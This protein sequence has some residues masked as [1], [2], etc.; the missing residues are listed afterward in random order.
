MLKRRTFVSLAA[1]VA[2]V[3][4]GGSAFAQTLTKISVATAPTDGAK[5]L[6]WG[7]HAGTF[8]K[9]GLDV[10]IVPIGS[11]AAA[12]AALAGGS[13]Q[14][15]FGNILSIASGYTRGVP[16]VI[17]A[18]GDIY[19]TDHPY[20]LL[21]VKKD[22]DVRTG[23]DLANKAIASPALRD[24]TSM[25]TLAWI[26]QNGGDS[27]SIR[28]L[29]FPASA[30]MSALD[31]SRVDA[32]TL[33]SP[34]LDAAQDSGKYRVVGKPYDAIAKRFVIASWVANSQVVSKDPQTYA[35]F[36]QAMRE[37]SIYS[38]S[39]LADTVDLVAQF[40]KIDPQVI[41]H[42]TRILDAEYLSR[43]DIQP[44]VDFAAKYGLIDHGFDTE[45]IISP[46]I[47]PPR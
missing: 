7:V 34:F 22:S 9:Y 32:A 24:L 39:H 3:A 15:A 12:L 10:E 28:T 30:A 1:G 46:A 20:M 35:R 16:F 45:A 4:G 11:G 29:E 41:A 31:T 27:K 8:R 14:V 5:A 37:A 25:A 21:F 23:K 42:G 44:V 17:V 47:R 6:L 40:T 2:L 33:S 26:D 36:S 19:T 38:N 43:A 18:P 13:A